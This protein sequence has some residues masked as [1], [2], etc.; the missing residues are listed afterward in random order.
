M[1]K[2]KT[3]TEINKEIMEQIELDKKEVLK[4]NEEN[5]VKENK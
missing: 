3:E 2:V 4:K 5:K 1:N